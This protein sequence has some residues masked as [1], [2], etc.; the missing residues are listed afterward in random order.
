M[1]ARTSPST[2]IVACD[3]K[4]DHSW[5][6]R[7]NDAVPAIFRPST[8]IL[9]RPSQWLR[10]IAPVAAENPNDRSEPAR[11]S[12]NRRK[13]STTPISS[14][15]HISNRLALS[16]PGRWTTVVP[17]DRLTN[18]GHPRA[19]LCTAASSKSRIAANRRVVTRHALLVQSR[20]TCRSCCSPS[21]RSRRWTSSSIAAAPCPGS[22]GISGAIAR[23]TRS[24]SGGGPCASIDPGNDLIGHDWCLCSY[25]YVE[26]A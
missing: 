25:R 15:R 3:S 20:M 9:K 21:R 5:R 12:A 19:W 14:E 23:A 7:N 26:R 6:W 10:A 24:S 13:R 11:S 18:T 17:P 8:M 1:S 2:Q 22:T 16:I 4:P